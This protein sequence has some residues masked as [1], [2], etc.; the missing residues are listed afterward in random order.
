MRSS[1]GR[2]VW[3][4]LAVALFLLVIGVASAVVYLIVRQQ[5]P[6]VTST[7][8]D[9]IMAVLPDQ[10]APDLA[11]YPLAGASELDAVDAAMD[12]GDLESAYSTLA[13]SLDMSD[14]Q[15][16]GRLIL[17]GGRFMDAGKP[18]RAALAYQEA[19]DSAVLSPRLTDPSRAEALLA[20][21]KGWAALGQE[22]L[23]LD[24]YEQVYLL[25]AQ[26][27]YLQMANR[28]DL[29]TALE[30][31]YRDMGK[32]EQAQASRDQIRIL[33]QESAHPPVS[34]GEVPDLPM[35][36]TVVSSP[37]VGSL[38]EIRR[39][40]AYALTEALVQTGEAPADLVDG[41]AQALRAE[42]A[43]KVALYRQELDATSQSGRRIAVTWQWIRWLLLKYKVASRG[44]GLSLVPEW[45]GQV[46]EI[47]SEL[48]KAYEGLFFD[49][50]DMVTALPEASLLA[51]GSYQVRRQVLLDG[52][53]GRYPNYPAEQLAAKLQ[54]AAGALISPGSVL[55]I[56]VDVGTAPGAPPGE[57]QLHFF[58]SPANEY[59]Q[60]SQS[61]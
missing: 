52:R 4:L 14:A 8:L 31:A 58:F 61:P 15:R 21:G 41:L 37:E 20:V 47:Q 16:I 34:P 42:E 36:E 44:F 3:I 53:L 9:P 43:A 22:A 5:Q 50:E 26:S 59:G 55:P 1:R 10:V 25:A 24:A 54:D 12:I 40:A 18:D 7:W 33:D 29:L 39:Q 17:L 57:G 51:P 49:Y 30:T 56:Y 6:S 27:P 32:A 23:A 11:L 35:G 28:R 13:Y 60:S 45:E 48:S 2:L 19:Y 46:P 38:E